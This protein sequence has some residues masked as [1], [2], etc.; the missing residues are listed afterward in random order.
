[1]FRLFS[2]LSACTASSYS[3]ST[4][5]S[6]SQCAVTCHQTYSVDTSGL[7]LSECVDIMSVGTV[8]QSVRHTWALPVLD[9]QLSTAPKVPLCLS[10]MSRHVSITNLN[11]SQ[12]RL[13]CAASP[14]NL[15]NRIQ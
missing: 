8:S 11:R 14:R 4:N 2:G 3:V 1:M 13:N 7:A 10:G 9:S 12:H 15:I 5:C 6:D